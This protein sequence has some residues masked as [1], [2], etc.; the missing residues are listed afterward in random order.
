[1]GP[2][3]HVDQRSDVQYCSF[4]L[5]GLTA[6]W[7]LY[8]ELFSSL[9]R[10]PQTLSMRDPD[11]CADDGVTW[12]EHVQARRRTAVRVRRVYL[13]YSRVRWAKPTPQA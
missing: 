3:W 10:R 2:V 11:D 5:R 1:M 13:F 6:L 7:L 12:R 9:P 8:S 4:Q